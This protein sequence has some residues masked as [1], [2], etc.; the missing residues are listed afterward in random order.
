MATFNR[1]RIAATSD[2]HYVRNSKGLWKDLFLY[3]SENADVLAICGDLTD[4]GLPEE[5]Q[6]LAEDLRAHCHIPVVAVFG[7]HD[8]ESGAIG[9]VTKILEGAGVHLLDG[10][11]AEIQN[12][13]F[14]GVRGFGGGF[15]SRMLA[16]WGEPATKH[17]VQESVDQALHLERA[18]ARLETTYRIALLHYSPIRDT[19]VGE[20]PE[21][22]PFLGSTRLEGPLNRF[23]VD[24]AFHGHAHNGTHEG[25][26]STGIP[27]Y[28][29]AASLLRKHNPN[30]PPCMIYSPPQR[31]EDE[32]AAEA[33]A[34]MI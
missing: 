15:G 26:T 6:V 34:V 12:V 31:E 17:F 9:E 18:L 30:H 25:A 22:F 3:A 11:C 29:V 8:F 23:K 2:L 32:A 28:N 13:G 19:I 33:G 27:V 10:E 5:A 16:A 24:A 4:Y 14:V 1:P 21:I 7:N 20:N